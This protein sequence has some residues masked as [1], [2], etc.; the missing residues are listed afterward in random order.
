MESLGISNVIIATD[1]YNDDNSLYVWKLEHITDK[2]F[3][4]IV[5]LAADLLRKAGCKIKLVDT[6]GTLT[7]SDFDESKR[8]K[9]SLN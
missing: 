6:F 2:G 8:L 3:D 9:P 7:I 5:A 4:N 1:N